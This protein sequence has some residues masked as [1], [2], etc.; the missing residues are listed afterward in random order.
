MKK[1]LATGL[2]LAGFATQASAAFVGAF[3]PAAWTQSPGD[4]AINAFTET[5]LSIS[6]GDAGSESFTDVAIIVS[7][8]G[9]I[10]FDWF[11]STSDASPAY[12]PFGVTT[13]TPGFL[14]TEVTD[15]LGAN[16]Q[17]GSFSIF[18]SAGQLFG[19]TA[20]SPDGLFGAATTRITNFAFDDLRTVPEPGTLALLAIALAAATATRRRQV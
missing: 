19:F 3:A 11:Y 8:D 17:S 1:L 14:F 6:S 5:D 9:Q 2:L 10:S 15:P 13:L 20:W 16:T 7:V 12:D 4:G 18:V